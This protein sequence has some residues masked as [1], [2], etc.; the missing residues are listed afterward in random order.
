MS[1]RN[2]R[3][4]ISEYSITKAAPIV[5]GRTYRYNPGL[6][7]LTDPT[8]I[9]GKPIKPGVIVKVTE[10]RVDPSGRLVWVQDAE[11][12]EQSVWK[13]ALTRARTV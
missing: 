9:S 7:D 1:Y 6:M 2:R 11:G 8:I 4:T 10:D 13:A 3:R 5:K 12:N